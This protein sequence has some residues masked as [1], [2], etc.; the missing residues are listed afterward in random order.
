M[1]VLGGQAARL[2]GMGVV[3]HNTKQVLGTGSQI[4]LNPNN[5][6]LEMEFHRLGI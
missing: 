4:P 3:L 6:Y 5:I 2:E 1:C